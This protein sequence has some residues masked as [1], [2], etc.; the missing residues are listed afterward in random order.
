MIHLRNFTIGLRALAKRFPG[1]KVMLQR[2]SIQ[3]T[4]RMLSTF[5]ESNRFLCFHF[6]H[7][8]EVV[9]NSLEGS[10]TPLANSDKSK[11]FCAVVKLTS[12]NRDKFVAQYNNR[13]WTD[14]A[15]NEHSLRCQISKLK[16]AD[17]LLKLRELN[18]PRLMPWG[19]VGTPTAYFFA[20]IQKC[21]MPS[22]VVNKL[23]LKFRRSGK[24]RM[25]SEVEYHY[26]TMEQ[27]GRKSSASKSAYMS[28][29]NTETPT[30]EGPSDED[31]C[32]EWERHEAFHEDCG[33]QE[34]I[35]ER[36][37][38]GEMEI[39]WEK[40]GPGLVFYTD[41]FH[42][43]QQETDTDAKWADEWD[44]D[45]SV[46]YK[47]PGDYDVGDKDAKDMIEIRRSQRVANGQESDSVFQQPSTSEVFEKKRRSFSDEQ[48]DFFGLFEKHT[49]G[50]GRRLLQKQGWKEGTALGRRGKRLPVAIDMLL[51]AQL[52]NE[53]LGIGYRGEKLQRYGL[54]KSQPANLI[55]TVYDEKGCDKEETLLRRADLTFVKQHK[56]RMN[57][58]ICDNI[59]PSSQAKSTEV[60]GLLHA[61]V[62]NESSLAQ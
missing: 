29:E 55:K 50:I 49:K 30:E 19:N 43:S 26:D 53:K 47:K 40:G 4:Q 32:E 2:K 11:T 31:E 58:S 48:D 44:I 5:T 57:A 37:Y 1:W 24:K 25:Y 39:V 14:F 7:R 9:L 15:G 56:W 54:S 20:E 28:L 22:S 61:V 45:M 3:K 18:P 6:L 21:N 59:L 36:L 52:P 51:M 46:Y 34:R 16:N 38:E 12:P 42:W 17:E 27:R 13:H 8:P 62:S 35:N 23:R 33:K 41:A 60:L 10:S